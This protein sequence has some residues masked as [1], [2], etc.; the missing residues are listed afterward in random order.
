[1]L[2]AFSHRLPWWLVS[3]SVGLTLLGCALVA[4]PWIV[5]LSWK[6]RTPTFSTSAAINHAIAGPRDIERYHPVRRMF[7]QPEVGRILAWEDPSVM[8]YHYWS[9]LENFSYAKH[10]LHLM[11]TNAIHQLV[12]LRDFDIFGI[13]LFALVNGVLLPGSLRQRLQDEPWRWA[14][15]PV[16]CLAGSYLPVYGGDKHYYFLTYPLL[17]TA[18]M[19]FVMS[20]T[21]SLRCWQRGA[22][23]VGWLLVVSSFALP[24]LT[25]L[26]V[27]LRGLEDPSVIAHALAM[28]LQAAHVSGPLAGIGTKEGLYMAFFMNQ[29]WY[30]EEPHPTLER[31]KTVPAMLYVIPRH[32]DLLAQLDADTTF[33]N[34]DS[35]L[36]ASAEEAQC[37]PWRVYQRLTR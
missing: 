21:R 12:V 15:L 26:P 20:L 9:P 10:Q 33:R 25:K 34:L 31:L 8:P 1:M 36:F 17:L 4:G 14:V 29:P 19:G 7:H 27:A 18:S 3:R 37:Y 32:A 24:M 30:G 2:W 16:I 13:G 6:Y 23:Y 5:V 11:Y 35:L 28:K 22:S